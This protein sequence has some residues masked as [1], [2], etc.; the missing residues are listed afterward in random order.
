M[1][2]IH[3]SLLFH[4]LSSLLFFYSIGDSSGSV[5][6]VKKLFK[7]IL[8]RKLCVTLGIKNEREFFSTRN[9]ILRENFFSPVRSSARGDK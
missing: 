1:F 6:N 8:S 2:F 7:D 4:L 3:F 9:N 5:R